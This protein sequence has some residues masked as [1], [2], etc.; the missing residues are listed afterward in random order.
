MQQKLIKMQRSTLRYK[1]KKKIRK[2]VFEKIGKKM[3][4]FIFKGFAE[5]QRVF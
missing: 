3:S 1:V 2:K 5:V 4:L